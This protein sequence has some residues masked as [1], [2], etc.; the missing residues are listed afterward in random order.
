MAQYQDRAS[1]TQCIARQLEGAG[2]TGALISCDHVPG[3]RL[4][5]VF[6][7]R[8]LPRVEQ[9]DTYSHFYRGAVPW[10]RYRELRHFVELRDGVRVV[11]H[12]V[13][14]V[15]D[16][17][18]ALGTV[19]LPLTTLVER[20]NRAVQ[21]FRSDPVRVRTIVRRIAP[22]GTASIVLGLLRHYREGE[23]VELRRV[24]AFRLAVLASSTAHP[25]HLVCRLSFRLSTRCPLG[26]LGELGRRFAG[27]SQDAIQRFGSRHEVIELTDWGHHGR[28]SDRHPAGGL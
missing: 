5:F 12:E 8:A 28:L 27:T 23:P 10:G 25:I 26:M 22:F 13:E 11:T 9:I 1:V 19:A 16:L 15:I 4:H 20:L 2:T 7:D 24:R 6:D 3:I 18:F 14:S 17:I 21:A